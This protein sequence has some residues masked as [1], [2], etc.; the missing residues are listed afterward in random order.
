MKIIIQF[1]TDNAAFEDNGINEYGYI[2][3]QAYERADTDQS[4]GTFPLF[5]SNGN[6]TGT[7]TVKA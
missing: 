4:P 3:T 6:K 7:V 5:D 1:K 2:M